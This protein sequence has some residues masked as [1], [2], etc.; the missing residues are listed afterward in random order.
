MVSSTTHGNDN[1]ASSWGSPAQEFPRAADGYEVQQSF[2]RGSPEFDRALAF[3]DAVFGF[4]LTLL[5]VNIDVTGVDTWS[6][7]SAL[8]SANGTEFTSFAIS[9][10][11]I[12][13]FWRENHAM[14]S[15]INCLDARV[16]ISNLVVIGLVI[17]I[18]FT[19]EAMGDPALDHLAL[20]TALYALNIALAIFAN[21]AMFQFALRD[22]LVTDEDPPAARRAELLDVLTKP[23]VFLLS[24]P[25]TYVGTALWGTAT[26]GKLTWLLLL[27]VAPVSARIAQRSVQRAR[28]ARPPANLES[29]PAN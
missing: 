16:M 29:T 24:I 19:T 5:V 18:P 21:I 26:P 3:F 1:R 20:P 28:A 8:W 7:V 14:V 4:A 17:F 22:G 9:F 25:V 6:S 13:S 11:V 23:A 12:V 2:E 15:R 27:V 10:V